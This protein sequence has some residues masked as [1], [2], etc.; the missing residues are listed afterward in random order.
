MLC[1]VVNHFIDEGIIMKKIILSVFFVTAIVAGGGA[2]W[3]GNQP[4]VTYY[5]N[6]EIKTSV[7]QEFFKEKGEYKVF[8][9]DGTLSQKFVVDNGVR[10]GKG[11]VYA[12]GVVAEVN[13]E[14]GILSGPLKLDTNG[15]VPSL[16]NLQIDLANSG[17]V[18]EYKKQKVSTD[19]TSENEELSVPETKIAGKITC[20]DDEFLNAM[21]AFLKQQTLNTFKDFSR[22]ISVT[23]SSF[24]DE[25]YK[26]EFDGVYVYPKFMAD[27]KIKC[28]SKGIEDEVSA[29]FAQAG[30]P[31]MGKMSVSLNYTSADKK[32]SFALSDDKGV[33]NQVQTFKGLEEMIE[34]AVEYTFSKQD[35]K[36]TIKFVS[37]LLK[38][39]VISDSQLMV[40]GKVVSAVM[41]EFNVIDG[42]S[43][44]WT[45][46]FFGIENTLT[47]Q[48][49]ITNKGLVLNI[50]YP[51]SKKPLLSVGIQ[52]N[53]KFKQK[54]KSAVELVMKEFSENSEDVA[55]EHIMAKL[56]EYSMSFSDV[57][58]SVNALLMN[59]KGEKVVG[60]V[61]NVKKGTDFMSA[62]SNLQNA[63]TA[64]IISY[65]N[66]KPNKV[67]SGDVENGFLADGK[68]IPAENIADYLDKDA[69]DDVSKQI[70]EEYTKVYEMMKDN[71]YPSDPF[72]RGFYEGYYDA[73]Q[74]Y[75][76]MQTVE[77]VNKLIENLRVVYADT[78]N[79]GNL[80]NELAI[81]L[82]TIPKEMITE[83]GKIIS[84]SGGEINIYAVPA[85]VGDDENLS[86]VVQMADVSQSTCMALATDEWGENT[87][88]IAIG[89]NENIAD[90]PLD[91]SQNDE[92]EKCM[93]EG[94]LCS[95]EHIMD[96]I[97]AAKVCK[98]GG[99]TLYFKVQ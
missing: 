56:P 86:F 18:F 90:L 35:S 97:E 68:I 73:M 57:I 16:D 64:K 11:F 93:T 80:S 67:I 79:Y 29:S 2:Y 17:Y 14:N 51:I 26:C 47:S 10:N 24:E 48:I 54:Y 50:A 77:Q 81:N 60:A 55:S 39:F 99:N 92:S 63:F 21:Q 58:N 76:S 71:K 42:F 9:Q 22:C 5:P 8:N 38:S 95:V 87:G 62:A 36:D 83:D 27:S 94:V 44:P 59:N 75:K 84:A 69:L 4:K 12:D 53:D 34:S 65:K 23:S 40:E 85:F 7:Q 46:S 49:K 37:D 43:D 96:V 66:N 61:F 91:V 52:V 33:Y 41:G 32:F 3:Y 74:Q 19:K 89:V 45:A 20:S 88:L 25:L 15:K 28:D 72:I 30:I 31:D 98:E 82:N 13:Y 70:E 6:G 78:E 1:V